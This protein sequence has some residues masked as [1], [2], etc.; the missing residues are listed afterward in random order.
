VPGE[1]RHGRLALPGGRARERGGGALEDMLNRA[2]RANAAA[3]VQSV[4]EMP[5][6]PDEVELAFGL[7][8]TGEVGNAAVC[9]AGGQAN[10]NVKLVWKGLRSTA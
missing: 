3:F 9:K 5:E 2:V 1:E 6:P 4:R 8:V 7:A 10:Y